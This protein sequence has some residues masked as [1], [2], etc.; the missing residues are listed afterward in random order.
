MVQAWK[1]YRCNL[2]F[3]DEAH[4]RM[5]RRVMNHSVAKIQLVVA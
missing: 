5:H 3:K 4:V 1:C 2:C